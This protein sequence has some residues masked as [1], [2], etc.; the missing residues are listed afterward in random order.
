MVS[1]ETLL[2]GWLTGQLEILTF[3]SVNADFTDRRTQILSLVF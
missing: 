1:F 2:T 3:E